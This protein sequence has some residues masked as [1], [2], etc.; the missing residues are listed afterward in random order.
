ME[1][2]LLDIFHSQTKLGINNDHFSQTGT[3]EGGA[4]EGSRKL[5]MNTE[6]FAAV[7]QRP[8]R[9]STTVREMLA[10][11]PAGTGVIRS[12]ISILQILPFFL[13]L[14]LARP[15][16]Y[17]AN[18]A[19]PNGGRV[20]VE[21]IGSFASYNNTLSINSPGVAIA[22]SG[23]RLEPAVGLGGTHVVSEETSQRGCRVDLDSDPATPGIQDFAAGTTFE[24]GMC[25]QTDSDAAC[26]FVWS[27]DASGNSDSKDHVL[28]DNF[29]TNAW[30]LSWEDLDELGDADFTNL[31][32][33]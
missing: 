16:V 28:T 10:K 3:L 31:A 27:S 8:D 25:A 4:M 2:V 14:T 11:K 32:T 12:G 33:N 6:D 1:H 23:C 24:F 22:F 15:N 19:I 17:A 20:S 9:G 26:E 30:R 29:A 5:R 21:L 18:L 13:L 7:V